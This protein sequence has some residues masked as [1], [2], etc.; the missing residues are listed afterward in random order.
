MLTRMGR[1]SR[2]GFEVEFDCDDECPICHSPRVAGMD[3]V[4][5][6]E[7]PRCLT[8]G[9]KVEYPYA[10]HECP[11]CGR[12]RPAALPMGPYVD[13]GAAAID[14]LQTVGGVA[15]GA[16]VIRAAVVRISRRF[17]RNG[18]SRSLDEAK[19]H[20]MS[21]IESGL[22][23]VVKGEPHEVDVKGNEFSFTWRDGTSELL[24]K[25]LLDNPARTIRVAER[26]DRV[27]GSS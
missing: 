22:G 8:C 18:A 16:A 4:P 24:A 7:D 17:R 26:R 3:E 23:R 21:A 5:L 13:L 9:S 1:C 19:S 6:D 12:A 27:P 11:I 2:C 15:G 14:T 20:A 10:P 25:G